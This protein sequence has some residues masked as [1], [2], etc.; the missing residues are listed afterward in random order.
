LLDGLLEVG[1]A[2]CRRGRQA[3]EA[4]L[5]RQDLVALVLELLFGTTDD[6]ETSSHDNYDYDLDDHP[7]SPLTNNG[8][9]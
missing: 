2:L 1:E 7:E 6:E 8:P 4:S 3:F 5:Q 9:L